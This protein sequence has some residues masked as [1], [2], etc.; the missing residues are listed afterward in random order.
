MLIGRKTFSAAVN[1]VFDL[2][3]QVPITTI[4]EP[5]AGNINHFGQVKY[6]TLPNTKLTVAYSTNYIVN[7]KGAIGPLLPDV[8]IPETLRDYLNGVDAALDFAINK[9]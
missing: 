9:H 4:G 5:T 7:K 8:T 6:F 3:A 2:S 1:N